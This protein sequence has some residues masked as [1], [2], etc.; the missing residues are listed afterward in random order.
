MRHNYKSVVERRNDND[1]DVR[2]KG[3]NLKLLGMVELSSERQRA[4][5]VYRRARFTMNLE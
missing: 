3:A 1:G 2:S 5:S 4:S